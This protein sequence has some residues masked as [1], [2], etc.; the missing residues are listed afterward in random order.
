MLERPA[1]RARP[2][3]GAE[4]L[5]EQ[6]AV[7][8]LDVDEVEARVGGERGGVDV[9]RD[10]RVEV[11]VGEERRRLGA[12]ALVEHGMVVGDP[13]LRSAGRVATTGRSA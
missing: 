7:T 8:V 10:E 2:V 6:V 12:D 13:R 1:V 3:D 9:G 4:Q 5:V 11:V